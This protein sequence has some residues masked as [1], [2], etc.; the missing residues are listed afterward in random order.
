MF[1]K[2]FYPA[3]VFFAV[4]FVPLVSSAHVKWFVDAPTIEAQEHGGVPF[5]YLTSK[6]VV[7]WSVIALLIVVGFSIFDRILPEPKKLKAF[8]EKHERGINRIVEIFIGL[9]LLAIT[10]LWGIV[11][12]PDLPI[13]SLATLIFGFVQVLS[14]LLLIFGVSQRLAALMFALIYISFGVMAGW[15]PFVENIMFLALAFYI[16][17]KNSPEG[18]RA[19]KMDDYSVEIVRIGVAISL[20][21]LAFT[22]KLMYPE[23]GLEFLDVHK[24]NFMQSL[25]LSWFSDNLFVL[26]AGFAEMIFGIIYIFGYLTRINT[27]V[28]ATFFAMSVVT[29]ALQFHQ[30]EMEDLPVYAAAVI[31]LFY[32]Y[33]KTRF[34]HR[35]KEDSVWRRI[36]LGRIFKK[37]K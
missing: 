21:V 29:M 35:M 11:V 12:S 4:L 25:G 23:L 18:S 31:F 5:Y 13:A 32:G 19:K 30:W 9:F 24:W 27:L 3:I 28:M 15:M 8:G 37:N 22:E 16:F 36:H 10:F 20:I 2:I 26:S 1:K 17:I 34:F 33:G 6:E 14:A 7:V